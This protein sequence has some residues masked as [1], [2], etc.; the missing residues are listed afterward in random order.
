MKKLCDSR[1]IGVAWCDL[2]QEQRMSLVTCWGILWWGRA[3]PQ[4]VLTI[5]TRFYN[6]QMLLQRHQS[7]KTHPCG[8][9]VNSLRAVWDF[10]PS[11]TT[12]SLEIL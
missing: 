10:T 11:H 4:L 5:T 9:E 7:N 2:P 12:L 8:N 3:D 6:T 1:K